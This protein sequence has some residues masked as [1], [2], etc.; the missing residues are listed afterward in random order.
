MKE[1]V[2]RTKQWYTC[3]KR[4]YFGSCLDA[5]A[6]Y[7]QNTKAK[8]CNSNKS[9]SIVDVCRDTTL[10]KGGVVPTRSAR[11]LTLQLK[12]SRNNLTCTQY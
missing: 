6:T 8:Y 10:L 2:G 5:T 1:K 7:I 3:M 4:E 11:R 9:T 12:S